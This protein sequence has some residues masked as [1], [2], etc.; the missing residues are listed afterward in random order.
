MSDND[1]FAG[2]WQ[3]LE[4]IRLA[5]VVTH[6]TGVLRGRPMVA[7]VDRAEKAIYFV[8]NRHDPKVAEIAAAPDVALS[9]VDSER[10]LYVS[11]SGT[12]EI[13]ADV[14]KAR[15]HG[16]AETLAWFER[17]AEDPDLRLMRVDIH[18]AEKWDVDTDPIRTAWEIG[19]SQL[20]SHTPDLTDNRKYGPD[21]D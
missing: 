18:Q 2:L 4:S 6:D 14:A 12:A 9:F 21:A 10:A 19:R 16:K 3:D 17:G 11:V 15:Q 5:M 1:E 20:S 8:V 13:V 7:S